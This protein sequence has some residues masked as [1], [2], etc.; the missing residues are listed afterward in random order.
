GEGVKLEVLRD[1]PADSFE[2]DENRFRSSTAS[3]KPVLDPE[4]L[5]LPL[6]AG[7]SETWT[8]IIEA[9]RRISFHQFSPQAIRSPQMI[10]RESRLGRDGHNAG[11]ILDRLKR[12]D[13]KWID[14]HL[15]A[16]VPGIKY[17]ESNTSLGWRGIAFG[18]GG[19]GGPG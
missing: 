17:A 19:S 1:E 15:A 16:T 14:Q 10:G 12:E 9:L 11:D 7:S 2:R 5:V 8:M 6:I 13:K 4:S 3:L 18:Q